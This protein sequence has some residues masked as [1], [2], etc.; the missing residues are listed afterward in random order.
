ME[1]KKLILTFLNLK[2]LSHVI[3]HVCLIWSYLIQEEQ[4]KSRSDLEWPGAT[5]ILEML[6]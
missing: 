5:D 2:S 6:F 1:V 3:V 4:C